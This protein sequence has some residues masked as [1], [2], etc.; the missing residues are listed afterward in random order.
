MNDSIRE[1]HAELMSALRA[2]EWAIGCAQT[3]TI[4]LLPSIMTS[5]E[6]EKAMWSDYYRRMERLTSARSIIQDL[7]REE[8]KA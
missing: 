3:H 4:A 7:I 8:E 6:E 2:I 5:R 1:K